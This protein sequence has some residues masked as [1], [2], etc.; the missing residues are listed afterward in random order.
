MRPVG[1]R[2]GD[3]GSALEFASDELKN[4]KELDMEAGRD[5]FKFASDELKKD[6]E[7]LKFMRL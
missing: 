2:G 7:V 5:G 6:P 4:D 1:Y 3:D